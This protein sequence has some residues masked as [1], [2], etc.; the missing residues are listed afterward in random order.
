MEIHYNRIEIEEW[1]KGFVIK[2][3]NNNQTLIKEYPT[4][5]FINYNKTLLEV[6]KNFIVR[7]VNGEVEY[8]KEDDFRKIL[9]N[10]LEHGELIF[11]K[12]IPKNINI[13][14]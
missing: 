5:C 9:P 12:G 10:V 6:H 7:H 8:Y 13:L 4:P 11:N 14:N 2:I 1:E 3:K